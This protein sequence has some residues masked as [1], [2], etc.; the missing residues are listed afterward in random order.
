[1]QKHLLLF[2]PPTR[3]LMSG[4]QNVPFPFELLP[5]IK[6]ESR[7]KLLYGSELLVIASIEDLAEVLY[8]TQDLN[9]YR[10][11]KCSSFKMFSF[12]FLSQK[13]GPMALLT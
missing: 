2:Y 12:L 8:L 11:T 7:F 13:T 1:M 3:E 4:L 5:L 6:S 10:L 9:G